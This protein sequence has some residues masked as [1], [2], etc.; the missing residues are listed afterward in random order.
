MQDTQNIAELFEK[1][2]RDAASVSPTVPIS[3]TGYMLSQ[4]KWPSANKDGAPDRARTDIHMK[5][6]MCLGSVVFIFTNIITD[7]LYSFSCYNISVF[8][9]RLA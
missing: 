6:G 1:A 8:Y 3:T 2:K 4:Q 9:F 7:I 5:C